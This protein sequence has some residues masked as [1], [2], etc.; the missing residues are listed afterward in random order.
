MDTNSQIAQLRTELA[1]LILHDLKGSLVNARNASAMIRQIAK[2]KS[3]DQHRLYVLVA[4]LEKSLEGSLRALNNLHDISA[5]RMELDDF[6]PHTLGEIKKVVKEAIATISQRREVRLNFPSAP[7]RLY[8]CSLQAVS[9]C[10]LNLLLNA[11]HHGVHAAPVKVTVAPSE[12]YL[13]VTIANASSRATAER[14]F[15][16][17]ESEATSGFGLLVCRKLC[18]QYDM[19]LDFEIVDVDPSRVMV[20]AALRIN[21]SS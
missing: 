1:A 15:Q 16:P 19:G 11:I 2:S 9:F 21:A 4:D 5:A 17:K 14:I 20:H 7:E 8:R 6:G 18:Q 10:V 3:L 12:G 13:A